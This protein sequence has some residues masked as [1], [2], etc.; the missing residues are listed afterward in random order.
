MDAVL[1]IK[2][3]ADQWHRFARRNLDKNFE[4][5]KDFILKRDDNTCYFCN[6]QAKN[7][8]Q[9][10]NLDHDYLHNVAENMVAS[11][12]F[13]AQCLFLEML[14]KSDYGGGIM[15]FLP[16]MSQEDLNG[17]CHV[18]FCAIVNNTEHL[19][20][21]QNIYSSIRL[22]AKIIE[23]EFGEG[24]SMPDMFGQMLLDTPIEDKSFIVGEV[25]KNIRVLPSISK[26]DTQIRSWAISAVEEMSAKYDG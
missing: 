12:P 16:E 7:H 3:G 8:M 15:V 23:R 6:F 9:V 14:G 26:F 25:E 24:M 19:I 4:T 17:L 20:N 1:K 18:L 22:R 11:C 5:F 13:C 10:V 2:L 21:A